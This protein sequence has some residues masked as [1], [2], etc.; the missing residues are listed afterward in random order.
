MFRKIGF[1]AAA[2]C[3]AVI[4]SAVLAQGK[5][6]FTL[7]N[8]TGYTINE[9]YVAPTKSDEWEEDVLDQDVLDN[10]ASVGIGFSKKESTCNYD[11]KVVFEDGDEA[12]WRKFDLCTVSKVTI[13]Y[14]RKTGD[15][16][17]QYE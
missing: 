12:D 3:V 14:N 1:A 2:A 15:T 6:D 8:R 5:Q 16:T 4:P 10:G 9:V 13:F 11:I 7:V 17:A